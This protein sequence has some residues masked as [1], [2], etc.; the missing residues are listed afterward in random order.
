MSNRWLF[1]L[2]SAVALTLSGC[3]ADVREV[4]VT[5]GWPPVLNNMQ[6][7]RLVFIPGG[8]FM[9]GPLQPQS[10]DEASRHSVALSSFYVM[11][12]EV[13]KEQFRRFADETN[14]AKQF[15]ELDPK[16]PGFEDIRSYQ[17]APGEYFP[18][19]AIDW[20]TAVDYARWLSEKDGRIYR[21]PT[22]AEWEYVCRAGT[23][24]RRWWGDEWSIGWALV[25]ETNSSRA[26]YRS[27]AIPGTGPA[28]PWGLYEIL[29]NAS[30]WTN[31]WYGP[32]EMKELTNPRGPVS[33]R[34]KVIRGGSV[35]WMQV[36]VNSFRR[37]PYDP[38]E[39]HA[40]IRLVCEPNRGPI[41]NAP[42]IAPEPLPD[43]AS[44]M[45][46][47]TVALSPEVSLDLVKLPSGSVRLGTPPEEFGH[48]KLEE[49]FTI[50]TISYPFLIG[51]YEVTQRQYEW[52][53][54]ANP[55]RYRHPDHPVEQV[56]YNDARNF[57]DTLTKRERTAGRLGDDEVY[58]LPT[59]PEWEYACRA[60]TTTAYSFGDDIAR[61]PFYAWADQ[62]G[63]TH[64]VGTKRPNPWGLYDMHGNV[65]EWCWGTTNTYPG[66]EHKDPMRRPGGNS[67]RYPKFEIWENL[68]PERLIRGG[69]YNFAPHACR[70]GMRQG[71]DHGGR[72]DF[73]GLRVVRAPSVVDVS[74]VQEK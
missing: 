28:N 64:P 25:R 5:T 37:S 19:F 62:V 17:Y 51:R 67:K 50:A 40:G 14:V 10:Q 60:G 26:P 12:F 4:A 18:I 36:A 27:F 30:E 34:S 71:F 72:Y 41:P 31:D 55:S 2:F 21:L 23:E 54:G 39:P 44:T 24:T 15:P 65:Q 63:G 35:E 56:T 43:P 9:M 6:G 49:P 29:G 32:Y 20:H 13:T 74:P 42:V 69:G 47:V 68:G 46:V 73:V 58:R 16:G 61:L 53:M 11:A 52:I 45:D 57:C 48:G 70:S 22:E 1:S 7:Q 59:E 3:A 8:T 33:G 66:G 38:R